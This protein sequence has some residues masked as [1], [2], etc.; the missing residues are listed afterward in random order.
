MPV[1]ERLSPK[2]IICEKSVGGAT[3][4]RTGE[5][6]GIAVAPASGVWND[7]PWAAA[8]KPPESRQTSGHGRRAAGRERNIKES[9]RGW[10]TKGRINLV[11]H[12]TRGCHA[13]SNQGIALDAHR[14][15]LCLLALILDGP[16]DPGG[17]SR[18]FL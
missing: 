18:A 16:T 2:T 5:I 4:G 9:V 3:G 13:L 15:T 12:S 11:Q 17:T 14:L 8:R 7:C 6:T 10:A 1:S